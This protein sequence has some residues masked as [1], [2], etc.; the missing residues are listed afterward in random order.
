MRRRSLFGASFAATLQRLAAWQREGTKGRR[1]RRILCS[2]YLWRCN[3]GDGIMRHTAALLIAFSA[4]PGSM[5]R[6]NAECAA[7]P[8]DADFNRSSAVFV[9]R[10][11]AQSVTAIP[12]LSWQRATE[13]TFEV[14][15]EWRGK[16]I[17]RRELPRPADGQTTQLLTMRDISTRIGTDSDTQKVL[18]AVLAHL[19]SSGHV[20]STFWR[21]RYVRNGC[22]R[23]RTRSSYVSTSRRSVRISPSAEITG[24]SAA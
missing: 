15:E 3:R 20:G 12:A 5:L 9:G 7:L 4:I 24:R 19:M 1:A 8:I 6:V 16:P 13:A 14:E 21:A 11:V 2:S 10:A 23:S 17:L 18:A 22:P